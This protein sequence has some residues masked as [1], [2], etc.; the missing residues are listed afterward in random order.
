VV[1]NVSENEEE[2]DGKN[3]KERPC[4]SSISHNIRKTM[5]TR[6]QSLKIQL[7]GFP[8]PTH[9][10]APR[11]PSCSNSR[12]TRRAGDMVQHT[13]ARTP[14]LRR[15]TRNEHTNTLTANAADA[16]RTSIAL[17]QSPRALAIRTIDLNLLI[18]E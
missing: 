17:I 4:I 3:G 2:K 1:V 7:E 18:A 15:R 16:L 5:S 8:L 12:V 13:I 6:S 11:T 14:E 10:P 9:C